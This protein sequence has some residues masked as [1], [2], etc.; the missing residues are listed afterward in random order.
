MK[1]MKLPNG[2]MINLEQIVSI[3]PIRYSAHPDGKLYF[4]IILSNAEYS[5]LYQTKVEAE[6]EYNKLLYNL[7]GI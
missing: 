4:N 3:E 5:Q 7:M 2:T 6:E 1:L